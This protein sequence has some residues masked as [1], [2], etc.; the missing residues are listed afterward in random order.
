MRETTAAAIADAAVAGPAHR[1]DDPMQAF[2]RGAYEVGRKEVTQHLRTKRLLI[3]GILFVIS[4]VFVTIVLPL[5]IENSTGERFYD[6]EAAEAPANQVF[7]IYLGAGGIGFLGGVFFIQ[8]LAI[9]LTADAVTSEWSHRTIFL[10][11]SKP[12]T[13][14]AFVLGKFLGSF[15]TVAVTF[16]SLF[17]LDYLA[18]L[19]VFPGAPSGADLGAFASALGI[20]VL[21]AAAYSGMALFLSTVTK[22]SV[23]AFILALALWVLVFP[24]LTLPGQLIFMADFNDAGP[25][26]V[27]PTDMKYEFWSY[28]D[29]GSSMRV[30]PKNM[31]SEDAFGFGPS[32]SRASGAVLALLVHAGVYVTAAFFVVQRRNFE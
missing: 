7:G 6:E 17:I 4:L 32:V 14:S 31:L 21:G 19:A 1:R 3:I 8:L 24:L 12:V 10:L 9:T 27:D 5:L 16:V 20:L 28:L 2:L 15:V 30:A 11:L 18:L 29:P 25:E 23:V 26:E 22:S 13:R